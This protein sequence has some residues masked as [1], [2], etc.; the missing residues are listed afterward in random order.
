MLRKGNC[1]DNSPREN[2]FRLLKQEMY[3][4]RERSSFE[5]LKK[6]IEEYIN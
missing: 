6:M 5:D 2:F 1:I 3:H 4:G